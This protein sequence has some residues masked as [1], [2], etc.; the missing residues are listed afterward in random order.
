VQPGGHL[1]LLGLMSQG[2]EAFYDGGRRTGLK[3][4]GPA[5][6]LRDVR[7]RRG[8]GRVRLKGQHGDETLRDVFRNA[9]AAR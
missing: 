5:I 9:P 8:S 6:T 1:R 3:C 7:Q 4:D 2:F